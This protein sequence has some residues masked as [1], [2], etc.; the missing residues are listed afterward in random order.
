MTAYESELSRLVDE[1]NR[2]A[3]GNKSGERT[4]LDQLLA[5]ALQRNASDMI[6]VA[7]S[8]VALRTN[9][10]LA[11]G[12]GKALS[13]EEIRGMLLPLLT[14]DQSEE[15]QREK[16]LDFCFVRGSTGRFRANFHYQRGTL[17]ASIRL[18]PAQIPSLESLHLPSGLAQLAER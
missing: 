16:S 17:A 9:G 1:L 11:S 14:V 7:G 3:P 10:S 12:V 4:S 18:L 6:L 8:P 13:P 15:L 2:S 5:F